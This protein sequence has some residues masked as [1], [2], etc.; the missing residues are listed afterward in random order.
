M[1]GERTKGSANAVSMRRTKFFE[2]VA[3][4]LTTRRWSSSAP[5]GT[6]HS[7]VTPPPKRDVPTVD[8]IGLFV[9][10]DIS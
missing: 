3:S 6:S 5:V 2:G 7:P 9:V 4:P 1:R 10:G 8:C